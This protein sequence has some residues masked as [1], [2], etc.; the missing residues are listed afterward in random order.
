MNDFA[1][2]LEAFLREVKSSIESSQEGRYYRK[3]FAGGLNGTLAQNI[4]GIN[5]ALS[6]IEENAKD[7][8]RNALSKNLMNLSLKSQN[9]NLDSIANTLN[10]DI[11]YMK[12]VD[13]NIRDIRDASI[14]SREDVSNLNRIISELLS[15]IERNNQFI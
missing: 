9:A 11:V 3:G 5:K 14:E 6:A 4:E 8:I 7:S 13:L 10:D 2:H 15:L 1:D 12:K